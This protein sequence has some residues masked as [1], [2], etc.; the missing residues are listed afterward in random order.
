M[1]NL[2]NNKPLMIS[3][4]AIVLLL[5]LA[6]V[7]AGSRTLT[8]VESAAGGILQPI[9][10]FASR[11]SGAII[12]FVRNT[13]NTTDADLENQQ[14]KVY[15]TQ[16]QES[17][18]ELDALRKENQRLKDLLNYTEA[19]PELEYVSGVVIG[20]SQG[21]W[22]DTFT[23]NIGRTSGVEKDMPVVNGNGL[24]GRVSAV[25]ATYCKVVTIIDSSMSVSVM[26]ER[27]RDMGMARGLLEA[28]NELDTL[29]L[30]Y[31]PTDTDLMPGDKIVT[32]GVGGIY[33]K[34]L[35]V[36]EVR[37]VSRTGA[38]ERNATVTPSVDFRHIEEVMVVVGMPQE[39]IV[40]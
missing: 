14:L 12:S 34:G 19:T 27:T 33:P 6:L 40:P 10:S 21:V 31:L 24:V 16:L 11:A 25:G 39:E 36:G 38:I 2:F 18:A 29:E 13:F 28:G 32:S 23:L 30:Y 4:A 37:E 5:I 17:V 1:R 3:L 8:F 20:R 35:I 26:V 22:F 9:Q 15:I 7:S